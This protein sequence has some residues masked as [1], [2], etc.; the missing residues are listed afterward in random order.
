M[1]IGIRAEDKS[2]SEKRTP[3]VPDDIVELNKNGFSIVVQSSKQRIFSDDEHRKKGIDV[4]NDLK[5]CTV[6]FGVKEIPMHVFEQDKL[7]IFFSHVIKG[8][9]YN[10]PMLKHMM[11]L[12]GT[13][14][15]YERIIDENNHRLVF[16]GYYAG[17][18]GMINTLWSLGKRMDVE[19][20]QNPFNKIQQAMTYHSLDDAKNVIREV[21]EEIKKHGI[22]AAMHPLVIGFAGYGNVSQGAQNVF[23][24]LPFKDIA[25]DELKQIANDPSVADDVIYKVVFKEK[26]IV[27]PKD[28]NY[29]FDLHDYYKHGLEK[30]DGI[31]D[32]YLDDLTVLVNCNYW[33]EKYPRLITL[34]DCQR[35]WSDD[36]QPRLQVI[37]DIS[38]DPHGAVQC[39]IKPT[40]PEQPTYVYH[41]QTG[42]A[43]D[44][45]EGHGPVIMAVEILP[46]EIPRESSIHF[47]HVLREF[48]PALVNADYKL[49]F[50]ELNLPFALKKALILYHGKLTPDY[51]YLN[52]YL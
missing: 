32:Q 9:T 49:S 19:N 16:F 35:M 14:I 39:T 18:S 23:D 37:S 27:K 31:F 40:Y 38:C 1:K 52:T 36:K 10:M 43:I 26:H 2:K 15:D 34:E 33:D 28:V 29:P 41:P 22:P 25:P 12:G 45:F 24:I 7:Y 17:L 50:E 44:G 6:I 11:E 20:I 51:E 47:S 42:T 46:T 21:G 8:Q 4:Q 48:I 30:Y 3:L 5:D 13:L